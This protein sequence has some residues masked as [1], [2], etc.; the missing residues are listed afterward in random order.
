MSTWKGLL[1]RRGRWRICRWL[2]RHNIIHKLIYFTVAL[3]W[4]MRI[5]VDV[6]WHATHNAL[7]YGDNYF[8]THARVMWHDATIGGQTSV[9]KWAVRRKQFL[10][11]EWKHLT[12][13]DRQRSMQTPLLKFRGLLKFCKRQVNLDKGVPNDHRRQLLISHYS[14]GINGALL[15]SRQNNSLLFAH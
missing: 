11:L 10:E 7:Q 15:K 14:S 5:A 4:R 8:A 9:N 2:R 13:R 1:F 3:L 6:S 12:R